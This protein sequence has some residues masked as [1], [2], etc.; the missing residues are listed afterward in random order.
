VAHII[1][2]GEESKNATGGVD[3]EGQKKSVKDRVKICNAQI[4]RG[5][6]WQKRVV[7]G[8]TTIIFAGMVSKGAGECPN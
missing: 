1:G 4:S 5:I 7:G 3:G 2:T 6:V 8:L